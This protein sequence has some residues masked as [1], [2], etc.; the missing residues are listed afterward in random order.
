MAVETLN[1]DIEKTRLESGDSDPGAQSGKTLLATKTIDLGA[2][3]SVIYRSYVLGSGGGGAWSP[4]DEA[5]L[6]AWYDA[7]DTDSITI[8]SG[9]D[10]SQLNDKSGNGYHLT[11]A[12]AS[13]MPHT[14]VETINS[15]N[16]L[17][18]DGSTHRLT[19]GSFPWASN[20]NITILMVVEV[21]DP[22]GGHTVLRCGD[23]SWFQ[24]RSSTTTGW[25][26]FV[27][28]FG[29]SNED[30]FYDTG[31]DGAPVLVEMEF[32]FAND[33]NA[34][35]VGGVLRD[36]NDPGY[37]TALASTVLDV[38]H[39][40]GTLHTDGKFAEMIIFSTVDQTIRENARAYLNTKWGL[41]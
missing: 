41:A 6:L 4:D 24:L 16:V 2:G 19:N 17:D 26:P 21:D 22:D 37:A 33:E 1:R 30:L 39:N 36:S 27:E 7:S 9:S 15:L 18:F 12:T 14:G 34:L 32:D 35:Y 11:E 8:D 23:S 29:A 13:E 20:N 38:M 40:R 5:S 3:R 25:L 31:V 10:V 28:M